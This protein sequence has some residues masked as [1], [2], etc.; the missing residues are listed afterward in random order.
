MYFIGIDVSKDSLDVYIRPE[1]IL[2]KF[3][4]TNKGIQ[5]FLSVLKKYEGCLVVFEATGGYEKPL[6]MGLMKK[7]KEYRVI[8][9]AR[10]REFAKACGKLAKTD[11]VDAQTLSAFA[12]KME[13]FPGHRPSEEEILLK[14]LVHRRQQIIEEIVREKNRLDKSF[15]E[16][17]KQNILSHLEN[18]RQYMKE[19]DQLISQLIQKVEMLNQKAK[20]I[21]SMPGIG[22]TTASVLLADF[23]EL[24]S[25]NNKQIA[26]L[27]GLAPMNKDSGKTRG[28][29]SISGGR[30]SVRCS[31]YMAAITAIRHN[32]LIKSFYTRLREKGKPA[33][34][35]LVACMR[36]MVTILNQMLMHNNF[37]QE[38][39]KI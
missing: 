12:E 4:N 32:T 2:L 28:Y 25:L 36:K 1:N 35:A 21:A 11:A 30:L 16:I 7:E 18:L 20:I 27:A 8:N 19:M 9:P 29:R 37:W 23:P 10:V 33:K 3:S 13:H 39:E 6:K 24:G 38:N 17:V 34:V 22:I 14:D 5:S 31:L 26:S 15:H